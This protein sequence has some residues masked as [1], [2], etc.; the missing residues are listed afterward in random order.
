MELAAIGTGAKPTV[1]KP[2]KP[3]DL[4]QMMGAA[5]GAGKKQK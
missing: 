2:A 3:F 5:A 4:Q 1:T